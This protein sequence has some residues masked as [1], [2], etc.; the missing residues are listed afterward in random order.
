MAHRRRNEKLIDTPIAIWFQNCQHLFNLT[1]QY[2]VSKILINSVDCNLYDD[3]TSS[4]SSQGFKTWE[5]NGFGIKQFVTLLRHS[6]DVQRDAA[7]GQFGTRHVIDLLLEDKAK[8]SHQIRSLAEEIARWL[9][10]TAGY[11]L[12]RSTVSQGEDGAAATEREIYFLPSEQAFLTALDDAHPII[13]ANTLEPQRMI[14]EAV[15][16]NVKG[17]A[18]TRVFVWRVASGLK[19]YFLVN[20]KMMQEPWANVDLALRDAEWNLTSIKDHGTDASQLRDEL[21]ERGYSL[22]DVDGPGPICPMYFGVARESKT[23]AGLSQGGDMLAQIINRPEPEDLGKFRIDVV[24]DDE[25]GERDDEACLNFIKEAM[26]GLVRSEQKDF[27]KSTSGP[28][29][30]LRSLKHCTENGIPDAIYVLCDSHIFLG[31]GAGSEALKAMHVGAIAEA[32]HSLKL[33]DD[34][35]KI[36]LLGNGIDTPPELREEVIHID[37]SLPGADELFVSIKE[38]LDSAVPSVA[39]DELFVVALAEAASGMTLAE[40]QTTISRFLEAGPKDYMVTESLMA[41][42][43]EAK[44][45]MVS[46][47]PVLELISEDRLPTLDLGGMENFEAWLKVR[48]KVFSSPEEAK[49]LGINSRPKGVLLLGVPGSGKSLAAKVMARKWQLPLVRLDI[50]SILNSLMGSSEARIRDAL[51]TI[52]AMAPCILWIDEIDKGMAEGKGT[53]GHSTD[54][55]IRATLLTWMQENRSPVFIVATANNFSRLPPEL[56][57]AGRFDA[58]FFFGCPGTE[59]RKHIL[60]IHLKEHGFDVDEFF[61]ENK[62][63]EDELLRKMHGFTGAE[64][65]QVVLDGLYAA[66]AKDEPTLTPEDLLERSSNLKPI[67]KFF[68]EDLNSLWDMVEQGRVEL[69]SEDML[70]RNH[71]AKLINPDLF[72]PMYCQLDHV[73]GFKDLASRSEKFLMSTPFAGARLVVLETGDPTWA[74]VQANFRYAPEDGHNFK[75]LE[76]LKTLETNMVLDSLIGEFGIERILFAE[77]DMLEAFRENNGLN[78][79]SEFFE[80]ISSE[81]EAN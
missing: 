45:E 79:Y 6:G 42:V 38:Q 64:I 60:H 78:I 70:R 8:A 31:S 29:G 65:E 14:N 13:L 7:S 57:R 27:A 1:S 33:R 12:C 17:E 10:K 9:L 16:A 66:F 73:S 23:S 68:G 67:I 54:L 21:L 24:F 55:N 59:G 48:K 4:L 41:A 81:E 40:T 22:H 46:R 56:T 37:I 11:Q 28:E 3:F 5:V 53:H 47:S 77:P 34:G 69:A 32:Y 15:K 75:F 35:I 30:F 76:R 26:R 58:R 25:L 61:F 20:G 62:E 50:G 52:E 51:K 49:Y 19:E 63:Q 71:V 36:V 80:L 72:R 39:K 18:E 2:S 44:R 74:H 43:R